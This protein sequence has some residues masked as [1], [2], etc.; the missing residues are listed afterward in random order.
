MALSG[1]FGL[2]VNKAFVF[3]LLWSAKQ[4][5][6]GISESGYRPAIT[7]SNNQSWPYCDKDNYRT[8]TEATSQILGILLKLWSSHQ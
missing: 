7:F 1:L 6:C 5:L 4:S 8:P 3:W 2:K